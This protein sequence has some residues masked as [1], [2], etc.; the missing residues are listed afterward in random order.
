MPKRKV[1]YKNK[2][3]YR[4]RRILYNKSKTRQL[5]FVAITA[6]GRVVGDCCKRATCSRNKDI[7]EL[8]PI[9][10]ATT[11]AKLAR[12]ENALA[13]L[14]TELQSAAPNEAAIDAQLRTIAD[15]RRVQCELCA[16]T[17]RN[18]ESA[19][20]HNNKAT[21]AHIRQQMCKQQNGCKNPDCPARG[22]NACPVLT[23]NHYDRNSKMCSIGN[24]TAAG[25]TPDKIVAEVGLVVKPDGTYECTRGEWICHFCHKLDPNSSTTHRSNRIEMINDGMVDGSVVD[26]RQRHRYK[27]ARYVVPKQEFNDQLKYDVGACELCGL[28]VTPDNVVTFSWDHRDPRTKMRG[29]NPLLKSDQHGMSGIVNDC[30]SYRALDK[31]VTVDGTTMFVWQWILYE[32]RKCRLLCSS[33]DHRQTHNKSAYTP[34]TPAPTV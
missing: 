9:G 18:Y 31:L 4:H 32:R 23:F 12:A 29:P 16:T 24:Y 21:Y 7:S 3:V 17:T 1:T 30:A 8:F 6:D 13:E 25:L 14:N 27:R 10:T 11:I 2:F 5:T 26:Q 28:P 33:C 19:K 34:P 20:T 15:N 22:M